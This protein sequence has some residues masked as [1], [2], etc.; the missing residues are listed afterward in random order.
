MAGF[1][2]GLQPI[3]ARAT[4]STTNSLDGFRGPNSYDNQVMDHTRRCVVEAPAGQICR[5]AAPG[6]QAT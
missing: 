5:I 6:A 4:R 3:S 1:Q 2:D